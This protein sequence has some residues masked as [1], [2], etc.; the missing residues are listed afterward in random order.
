MTMKFQYEIALSFAGEDRSFAKYISY[1]L[2]ARS[3]AVF[4]DEFEKSEL[5]GADLSETLPEKYRSSRYCVILQSEEY[6]KKLWTTLERQTLVHEFLSRRGKDY[7]LPIRVRGCN[8]AIPGLS[9]LVGHL[10]VRNKQDWR[11]TLE[12]LIQKLTN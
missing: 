6:L 7:I 12:L 11:P 8:T 10:T 4:Y 1:E 5:W 9:E 2:R 3:I